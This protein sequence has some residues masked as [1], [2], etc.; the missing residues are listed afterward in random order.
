[1]EDVLQNNP[2]ISLSSIKEQVQN[3]T[4]AMISVPNEKIM[5]GLCYA[6][7]KI[8]KRLYKNIH[9]IESQVQEVC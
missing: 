2:T 8:L 3:I 9:V 6:V 5:R 4:N 7:Q 1:M